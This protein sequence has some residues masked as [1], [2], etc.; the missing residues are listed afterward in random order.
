MTPNG[1]ENFKG[2]QTKNDVDL[3]TITFIDGS[4]IIS[5]YDHYFFVNGDKR[6]LSNLIIGDFIDTKDGSIEIS[7]IQFC[8]KDLVYDIV[9]VENEKHQFILGNNVISKNCDEFAFVHPNMASEFWTAIQPTL[10]TGGGCII[11]STPNGDSDI[12]AE[13]W[14]GAIDNIGPDGEK[15]PGGRGRNGFASC[16][17]PWF[18]HPDRDEKW[19]EEQR[20]QLGDARFRREFECEFLTEEETLI[21]AM[22]LRRLAGISPIERHGQIR[23][24]NV[25][26]PNKVYIAGLDPATGTGGERSA[27]QLFML[28]DMIQI[29]EWCDNKTPPRQQVEVMMNILKHIH[30][31]LAI[32]PEQR[33]NPSDAIYW[34]FENNGIGEAINTVIMDTGEEY[35]PGTLIHEPKRSGIRSSR[36]GLTTSNKPKL[37]ACAKL[38][39]LIETDRFS[40]RSEAMIQELKNY[41]RKGPG[42]AHKP[43][44]TDDLISAT[45]LNLRIIEIIKSYDPK[46]TERLK[47]VVDL[48]DDADAPMPFIMMSRM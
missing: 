32:H 9:E 34:T 42:F 13:V 47:D 31:T 38:K 41:I 3:Y 22:T 27:I 21:D 44:Q 33:E 48:E 43:G 10:S 46:I 19:A 17:A 20:N 25:V 2:V 26:E 28:P 11:T 18:R 6:S 30:S 8:R 15:L 40:I 16:F 37:S 7:D 4:E 23:W 14:R 39:S 35:F 24:Y 45:L 5:S 1:W 36:R 12:F 29:A